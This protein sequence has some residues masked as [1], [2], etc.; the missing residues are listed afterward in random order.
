MCYFVYFL[1]T[2]ND[3]ISL[4]DIFSIRNPEKTSSSIFS[5]YEIQKKFSLRY[6]QYTKSG[7]NIL[8]DISDEKL[9][10]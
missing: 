9:N 2:K 4:F 7:K 1:Y 8:F 5:V 10:I 3:K 6:F